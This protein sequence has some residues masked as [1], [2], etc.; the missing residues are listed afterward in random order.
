[1]YKNLKTVEST[2]VTTL[3]FSKKIFFF[4]HVRTGS[5]F[6]SVPCLVHEYFIC[7]FS[8]VPYL[9]QITKKKKYLQLTVFRQEQQ[10]HWPS[11][12]SILNCVDSQPEFSQLTTSSV[13]DIKST[14]VLCLTKV[15]ICLLPVLILAQFDNYKVF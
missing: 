9:K 13:H 7:D 14:A 10:A 12:P 3:L 8:S 4:L 11:P 15:C 6:L 5:L 2:L 1:M